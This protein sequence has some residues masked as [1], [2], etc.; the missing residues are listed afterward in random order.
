MCTI[1]Q[2]FR[3]DFTKNIRRDDPC[4]VRLVRTRLPVTLARD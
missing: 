1:F 4:A 3:T 2:R